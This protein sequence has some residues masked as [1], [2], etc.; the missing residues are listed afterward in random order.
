MLRR[1]IEDRRL[2]G[3]CAGLGHFLGTDPTVIRLGWA[4]FALVG[5]AGV[6]GYLLAWALIPDEAGRHA[7]TPWLL[8][9]VVVGIPYLCLLVAVMGYLALITDTILDAWA[10]LLNQPLLG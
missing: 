10:P 3:V 2:A 8:L 5:G 1:P 4:V 9:L 7:A 6:L